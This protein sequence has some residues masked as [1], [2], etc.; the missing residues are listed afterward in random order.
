MYEFNEQL[1]KGK[2]YERLAFAYLEDRNQMPV[3]NEYEDKKHN[4][5][6]FDI[7]S[8]R[9]KIEVKT[10]FYEN[11]TF[12]LEIISVDYESGKSRHGWIYT[13]E[14][15]FIF[16]YKPAFHEFYVF[17]TKALK[18][19]VIGAFPYIKSLAVTPNLQYA[20]LNYLAD[21]ERL[22]KENV[23]LHIEPYIVH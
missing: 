20:S 16:Y 3:Y 15:D 22:K 6:A 4:N 14:S 21:L 5:K 2:E 18:A 17:H 9:G 19:F 1:D 12:P 10:C 13:T 7:M 23:L 11:Y 8:K